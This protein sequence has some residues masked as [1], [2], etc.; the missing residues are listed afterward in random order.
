MTIGMNFKPRHVMAKK[1]FGFTF[2]N[3]IDES[4][5]RAAAISFMAWHIPAFEVKKYLEKFDN[6]L[7]TIEEL[8]AKLK[9]SVEDQK[10]EEDEE[11]HV[12][13]DDGD[14]VED[15]DDDDFAPNICIRSEFLGARRLMIVLSGEEKADNS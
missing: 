5:R 13:A 14:G 10:K 1:Y 8:D 6:A 15:E 4:S 11:E 2:K 9:K 3:Q 7:I 12:E